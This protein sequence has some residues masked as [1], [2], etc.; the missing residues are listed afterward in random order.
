MNNA[1]QKLEYVSEEEFEKR[2]ADFAKTNRI[3]N[4]LFGNPKSKIKSWQ[5]LPEHL[6]VDLFN[7]LGCKPHIL[8][9]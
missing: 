8:K 3:L 9:Y 2:V 1:T 5:Q 4:A 7:K 6:I